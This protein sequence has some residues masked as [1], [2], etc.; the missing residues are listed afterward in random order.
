MKKIL[1]IA[2]V[3]W[4][5]AGCE[6]SSD[7]TQVVILAEK[8]EPTAVNTPDLIP[9]IPSDMMVF[10]PGGEFQMGCEPSHNGGFSCLADE[11]P[12]HAVELDDYY[13][14]KFEISN[15]QYSECVKSGVCDLPNNLSSETIQD[16][17]DDP[18]YANYPVINVSW[19]DADT[20]CKWVGKRL[21]TEAEWEKAARGTKLI[22]YPWGDGEPSCKLANIFDTSNSS[23]CAGDTQ[24]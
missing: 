13:I 6:S 9:M 20:Y 15:S 4:L 16:Y 14:D 11:L 2:I 21:P 17:F 7:S 23:S 18:N 22:S 12:L 5:L 8:I 10:I 24:A 1:L 19:G 3:F